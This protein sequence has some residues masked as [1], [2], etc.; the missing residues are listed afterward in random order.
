VY[1]YISE[2][3]RRPDPR[4]S[5]P[6][7][8]T[9]DPARRGIPRTRGSLRGVRARHVAIPPLVF[10]EADERGDAS[11]PS[12]R[13]GSVSPG[14]RHSPQFLRVTSMHSW[15]P[16]VNLAWVLCRHV[17]I[18]EHPGSTQQATAQ[19]RRLEV[20]AEHAQLAVARHLEPCDRLDSPGLASWIHLRGYISV[21]AVPPLV[22]RS[23]ESS[24]ERHDAHSEREEAFPPQIW[25]LVTRSCSTM[26]PLE[27]IG[28]EKTG[29]R[30]CVANC[31][32]LQRNL[33][34]A[35]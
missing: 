19:V 34:R 15:C 2:R 16:N 23:S 1:G 4:A 13:S 24:Q 28:R 29:P 12:L 21:A 5:S 18:A 17:W 7:Y 31:I 3:K 22:V 32:Y 11:S 25:Q 35:P 6:L 27:V 30:R 8:H 10:D 20:T 9:A 33:T 14:V 26:P